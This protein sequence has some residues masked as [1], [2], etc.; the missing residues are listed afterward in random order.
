M[1]WVSG[2]AFVRHWL[3]LIG[4]GKVTAA[5]G[6]VDLQPS[7]DRPAPVGVQVFRWEDVTRFQFVAGHQHAVEFMVYVVLQGSPRR[8][9]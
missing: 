1:T 4:T 7:P 3:G 8:V 9:S 5:D 2:L 6:H